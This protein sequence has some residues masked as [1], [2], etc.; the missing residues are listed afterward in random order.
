M[1]E[2]VRRRRS[3]RRYRTREIDQSAIAQLKEAVLRS[4]TSRNLQPWHFVFVTERETLVALSQAKV[5]YAQPLATAALG[6]VVCGD[7][8]LSD[9]WIEDCSIAATVLQLVATSL[10]LGSCWIQMRGR[11]GPDGRPAEDH[12]REILGLEPGL[13]VEC[14][15]S[16]GYPAEDKPQVPIERL[17]W[18][19]ILVV[20]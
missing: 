15:V 9:C 11:I 10:G 12:V 5:Q 4:P 13:R 8:S 18:D 16:I 2:I 1:L 17:G 14:A 3:I 7:E 20:E 6:V 19:K